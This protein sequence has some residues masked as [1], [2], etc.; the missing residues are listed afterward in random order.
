MFKWAVLVWAC[1]FALPVSAIANNRK[2]AEEG[3]LRAIQN[4]KL[5]L[6]QHYLSEL[7][8]FY[9]EINEDTLHFSPLAE[10]YQAGIKAKNS[11]IFG[12][13]LASGFRTGDRK[14]DTKQGVLRPEN[15]LIKAINEQNIEFVEI[16]LKAK[17]YP[18]PLLKAPFTKALQTQNIP[19]IALFLKYGLQEELPRFDTLSR[20]HLILL[21]QAVET[22]LKADWAG[23]EALSSEVRTLLLCQA[24]KQGQLPL[25]KSL[26][27]TELK[28]TWELWTTKND[29]VLMRVFRID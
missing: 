24:L 7:K 29:V 3:L 15:F 23:I 2:Q 28:Y 5:A 8:T 22:F 19:L 12:F 16:I 9:D 1:F 25:A 20:D 13:L 21:R 11:E 14:V 10:A 17:A 26:M 27:G 18:F 6:V 4:Q